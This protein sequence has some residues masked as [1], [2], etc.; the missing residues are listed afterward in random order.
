L[1]STDSFT[2]LPSEAWAPAKCRLLAWLFV[3]NRVLTPD[4]LMARQWPNSYFC[5]LCRRTWKRLSTLRELWS[6]VAARIGLDSFRPE[7]WLPPLH[8]PVW[9]ASLSASAPTDTKSCRSMA[10]LVIW[11]IWRERNDRIFR[12]RDR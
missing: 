11:S 5:P 8:L 4:R 3:Q 12:G 10:L 1:G 9:L 6:L 2:W 7:G